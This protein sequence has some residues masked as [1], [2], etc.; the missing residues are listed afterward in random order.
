MLCGLLVVISVGM[1][2][3]IY[4][5]DL[6]PWNLN[7]IFYVFFMYVYLYNWS[8]YHFIIADILDLHISWFIF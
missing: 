1:S 4:N 8:H 7:S 6:Q 2:S 3:I 5:G